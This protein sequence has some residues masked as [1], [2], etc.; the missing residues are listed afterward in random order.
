[1]LITLEALRVKLISSFILI[2][3]VPDTYLRLKWSRGHFLSRHKL[4][5]FLCRKT[6]K[7]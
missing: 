2:C 5:S 4:N 6:F 7:T 1:M 3:Y